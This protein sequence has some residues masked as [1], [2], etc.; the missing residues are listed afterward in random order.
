MPRRSDT[1]GPTERRFEVTR[2]GTQHARRVR[3]VGGV[4]GVR[5]PPRL[6]YRNPKFKDLV[7]W[8]R[9]ARASL[10]AKLLQPDTGGT[11]R[12]ELQHAFEHDGLSIEHLQWR[13][14]YGPPTEA[15]LLRP[16]TAKGKL[17]A[18]VALH[19]HGGNKYFGTRKILTLGGELHPLMKK[20][21]HEYYGGVG[22]ANELAK[23]GYA[24]LV[25]DAF[26]FGSRR[27]RLFDVPEVLRKGLK[28]V[29]PESEAEI[30]GL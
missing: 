17:P 30:A 2:N 13:L 26:L 19:D 4:A 20:H 25:H 9:E 8:R 7:A 24:V 15:Y 6:S 21:Q 14:P 27:V 18:V 22:W 5:R 1:G 11:P 10:T 12:A 29:N 28:E 16:A 23:R 3:P